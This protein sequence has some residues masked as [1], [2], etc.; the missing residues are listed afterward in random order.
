M[1]QLREWMGEC[2]RC[3]KNVD[4]YTMSMF[5]VTLICLEC[6]DSEKEWPEYSR[7]RQ[8]DENAIRS[9]DFNYKGI[10]LK[11]NEDR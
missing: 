3:Y 4:M 7:A 9:G 6:A 1:N 8:A 2:Q 10:G 5:D 11:R